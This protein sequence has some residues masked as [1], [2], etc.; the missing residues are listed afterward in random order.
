MKIKF[1]LAVM[2]FAAINVFGQ[3][4]TFI[5]ISPISAPTNTIMTITGT[6]LSNISSVTLASQDPT[7]GS[8]NVSL[9]SASANQITFKI[10]DLA[11]FW[12]YKY[13]YN[14]QTSPLNIKAN[15][16][17]GIFTTNLSYIPLGIPEITNVVPGYATVNSN[18]RQ[19]IFGKY[20]NQDGIMYI[21]EVNNGVLN[22]VYNIPFFID[23]IGNGCVGGYIA[24]NYS[25]YC[26]G[27]NSTCNINAI[28]YKD[29]YGQAYGNIG[30]VYIDIT[31]NVFIYTNS[32][33]IQC[34]SNSSV[35]IFIF[36]QSPNNNIYS[37]VQFEWLLN[38]VP[39]TSPGFS[40]PLYNVTQ[41]GVYK[42]K[43]TQGNCVYYT[44]EIVIQYLPSSITATATAD[45]PTTFCSG[46]FVN[47]TATN[48]VAATYQWK[49]NGVNITSNG[50]SRTYKAT[51]TGSY[52]CVVTN[53]CGSTTTNAIQ[54]TTKTNAFAT[55]TATGATSFCAGDSVTLNCTNLGSNYSVQ[56]YRTNI[57]M[58]NATTYT[59]VVKQPGTYKVV[60]KHLTNG[61]SRISGSSV[62]V[63]VNCR[64]ANPD[65][66]AVSDENEDE[67]NN[68]EEEMPKTIRVFPNPNAGSFTFE[69]QT[70]EEGTGELQ[71]VNVMGQSI[72]NTTVNVSGGLYQQQIEL[73]D[74]FPKG[75]YV[76]RFILNGKQHDRKLVLQ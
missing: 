29:N 49:K 54:V 38:G 67:S 23:S 43:I 34:G 71:I 9:L 16:G 60:T 18:N 39:I 33:T 30:N 45:G 4:P 26:Y 36:D 58:E 27:N 40:S 76:V 55:V 65:A 57:S 17:S 5:S 48:V 75:I 7:L 70:S 53:P 14:Y 10:P 35:D 52:T 13:G 21:N 42:L 11:Y 51:A 2:L 28:S 37:C 24:W 59:K 3:T 44:N 15:S 69:Y 63:A 32:N 22:A 50:T 1:L 47:L 46:N 62:T 19:T 72:Y 12:N 56:W 41:P 73:G 66:I 6:N 74:N 68:I 20:L 25:G 31:P 64:M 61:C 8:I